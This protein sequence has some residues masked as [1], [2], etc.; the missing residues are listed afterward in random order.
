VETAPGKIELYNEDGRA[1]LF[2]PVRKFIFSRMKIY[3]LPYENLFSPV[4]KFI[5]SRMKIYF[6]PYENLGE[7]CLCEFSELTKGKMIIFAT[8][9]FKL[10]AIL[11]MNNGQ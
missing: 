7:M 2:S 8:W 9:N 6:L 11:T 3:F 4:Y 10:S 1:I 5:F